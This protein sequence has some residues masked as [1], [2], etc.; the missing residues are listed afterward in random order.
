MNELLEMYEALGRLCCD[1]GTETPSVNMLELMSEIES[2]IAEI[3]SLEKKLAVLRGEKICTACG[4]KN[5]SEAVYCNKCGN[6]LPDAEPAE[7]NENDSDES[8]S[9]CGCGCN[10]QSDNTDSEN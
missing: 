8:D 9:C 5:V 1:N 6:K 3:K 2:R 4:T 7:E 10:T